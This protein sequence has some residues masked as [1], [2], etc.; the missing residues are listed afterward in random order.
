M[1][2]YTPIGVVGYSTGNSAILSA[3]FGIFGETLGYWFRNITTSTITAT[4]SV[5]V[6]FIKNL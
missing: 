6:M 5:S 2:G 4:A 3:Q 1:D